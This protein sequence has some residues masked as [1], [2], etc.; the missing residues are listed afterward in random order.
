MCYY[1]SRPISALSFDVHMHT[2]AFAISMAHCLNVGEMAFHPNS[3][4]SDNFSP[5]VHTRTHQTMILHNGVSVW[6]LL[7]LLSQLQSV[8]A[9][10][11]VPNYTDGW[12][13]HIAHVC[14]RIAQGSHTE[15]WQPAVES[16]P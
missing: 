9:L 2:D 5:H 4:P 3:P 8:T 1:V 7:R 12:W 14:E 15:A 6:R 16:T 10:R 11:P 13:M